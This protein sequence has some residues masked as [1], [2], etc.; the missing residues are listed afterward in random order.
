[1]IN[2]DSYIY[3]VQA[4]SSATLQLIQPAQLQ[5]LRA[6]LLNRRTTNIISVYSHAAAA[7]AAAPAAPASASAALCS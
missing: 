7:H 4:G 1:M 3:D 5:F 2:C 6:H